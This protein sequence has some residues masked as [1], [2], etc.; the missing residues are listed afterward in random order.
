MDI[1]QILQFLKDNNTFFS[2]LVSI[3]LVSITSYYA[4]IT[5]KLLKVTRNQQNIILNPVIGI[6]VKKIEIGKEWGNK[7]RQLNVILDLVNVGN[8]PAIEVLIDSEIELR[9]SNIQNE[10]IIPSRFEPDIIPFIK[11]N[12]KKCDINLIY[13]NT[14]LLHF[15][16]DVREAHRLN[17]H[18]ITAGTKEEVYKTSKLYVNLYYKNSIGQYFYSQFNIEIGIIDIVDSRNEKE[19]SKDPIPASNEVKD[20][21]MILIPR[22]EFHSGLITK[23]EIDNNIN[24]SNKKRDLC[25]W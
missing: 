14:F 22:P 16:N 23:K 8:S 6:Q 19:L 21:S 10:N 11:Q 17:I 12:E 5:H 25:G 9:Y 4:I 1:K 20:V 15:F 2:L 24:K 18:R 13:G 7:R 3:I